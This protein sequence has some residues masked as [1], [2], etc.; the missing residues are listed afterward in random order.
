[1]PPKTKALAEKLAHVAR[2]K[3]VSVEET[4]PIQEAIAL[5][6]EKKIHCLMV[7]KGGKLCGV[8]TDR[9]FLMKAFGKALS[10][11]TARDY[12]TPNPVIATLDQSLGEAVEVMNAKGLRNLPLVD[13]KGVPASLLT[14]D[15]VIRYLADHFP[16]A[17]VNRSPTPHAVSEEADGA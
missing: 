13:E 17:V 4:V 14:V 12:M 9:D 7:T 6:R 15:T 2:T 16:A 1:M 11:K 3:V 5:M 8:F 10:G